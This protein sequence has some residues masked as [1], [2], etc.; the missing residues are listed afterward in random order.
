MSC[1]P[2]NL[3]GTSTAVIDGPY[4]YRLSRIWNES[5]PRLGWVMLNPSTADETRDDPTVRR[6]LG[7]ARA[8]GMGAAG[9]FGISRP[10]I[11]RQKCYGKA[12]ALTFSAIG[13][14]FTPR[15][16]SKEGSRL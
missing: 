3:F 9:F 10:S 6:C 2:Q 1:Y 16:F 12:K 7:F 5:K 14:R 13:R 8:W 15:S 11:R 4:R